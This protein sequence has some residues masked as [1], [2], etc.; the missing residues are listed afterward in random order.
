MP[1]NPRKPCG[2]P[3]CPN[4]IPVG[5]QFCEVHR[6]DSP[7]LEAVRPSRSGGNLYNT[8]RWRRLRKQVLQREPFCRECKKHG[9]AVMAT[10]VDHIKSHRGNEELF[11]DINNL[12]PLC[13]SCHSKKT[14]RDDMNPVYEYRF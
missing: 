3:T 6:K 11:W 14:R 5:Q 13:H 1:R 7:D 10:D 8:A 9:A 12:Q 2:C 4:L